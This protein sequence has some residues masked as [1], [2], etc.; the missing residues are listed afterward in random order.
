MS[1]VVTN[2]KHPVAA[3]FHLLFKVRPW[4]SACL[5]SGW[6]RRL[7][8]RL[9]EWRRR[10]VL[11]LAMYLFGGLFVESFVFVF[12]VCILLLA[13]DFWTVKVGLRCCSSSSPLTAP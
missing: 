9:T 8:D 5:G 3:F 7:T 1:K 10:Q 11:A 6:C 13:F 4:T 2:A 12:V